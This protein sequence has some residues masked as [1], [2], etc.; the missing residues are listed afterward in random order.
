MNTK[1][2]DRNTFT[3]LIIILGILFIFGNLYAEAQKEFSTLKGKVVNL[4]SGH[5]IPAQKVT[6][7][8][9][10]NDELKR[11]LQTMTNTDGEY[12][13]TDLDVGKEWT[14]QLHTRYKNED[15]ISRRIRLTGFQQRDVHNLNVYSISSDDGEVFIEAYH[16]V[17]NIAKNDQI[18]SQTSQLS[19]SKKSREW[20]EVTEYLI[21]Q[22]T[23]NTSYLSPER[24][25]QSA[26][27]NRVGLKL[28]LPVG[29]KELEII[30]GLSPYHLLLKPDSIFHGQA[31]QP[32]TLTVAFKYLMETSRLVNL[33]RKL[34]F[35][36]DKFLV[37]LTNPRLSIDS[38]LQKIQTKVKSV[39]R[40]YLDK[41][42]KKG[43]DVNL[44]VKIAPPES[45]LKQIAIYVLISVM[46]I[47]TGFG[48]YFGYKKFWV[49]RKDIVKQARKFDKSPASEEEEYYTN[50]KDVYLEII[51]VL[52]EMYA[53][54]K[55]GDRA[56]QSLYDETE[57]KLRSVFSRLG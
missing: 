4:T 43:E 21:I 37:I 16:I 35:D 54:G 48:G 50:L 56:Y 33:S 51:M 46:I 5:S 28:N 31:I 57:D 22:N 49:E 36:T 42:L 25:P 34:P 53:S 30:R 27:G 14:Y 41:T 29:Y 52:D 17:L 20:L 2:M 12:W 40:S 45:R 47:G 19:L 1:K 11:E 9:Y 24:M 38:K 15:Y 3:V 32:G 55:I 10:Q 18:L 13:F 44:K 26:Y 23:G 6:L 39:K 7:R 8:I